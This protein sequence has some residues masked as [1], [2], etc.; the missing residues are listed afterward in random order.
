[1]RQH[2]R[3]DVSGN[4]HD[5]A[6]TGLRFSKLGDRVMSQIVEAQPGQGTL[7]FLEVGFAFPIAAGLR[8]PLLLAASRA[9]DYPSIDNLGFHS[10]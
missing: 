7:H 5:C 1:V 3:R 6:I 9:T 4:R 8:G 2:L 10:S